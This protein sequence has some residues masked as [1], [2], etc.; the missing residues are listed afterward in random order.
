LPVAAEWSHLASARAVLDGGT[1]GGQTVLS[2]RWEPGPRLAEQVGVALGV[3]LLCVGIGLGVATGYWYVGLSIAAAL[4]ATALVLRYP[5][6]AVLLW[7]LVMPYF[8]GRASATNLAFV[9]SVHRLLIPMMLVLLFVYHRLG[10]RRSPF[11]LRAL[12]GALMLFIAIGV[13]NVLLT[14]GDTVRRLSFFHDQAIVPLCLFWLVRAIG[15]SER[16]LRRLVFV[17]FITVAVQSAV[18]LLSWFGPS[19]LPADWAIRAGER[20]VGTIGSPAP[21]TATIVL[22]GIFLLQ[23]TQSTPSRRVKTV[24]FVLL[25]LGL[26]AIFMSFSRGSWVGASLVFVGLLPLYPR[27]AVA[28]ATIVVVAGLALGAGPLATEVGFAQDRLSDSGTVAGRLVTDDAAVAMAASRPLTGWGFAQFEQFDEQFKR[29]VGGFAIQLGGSLHN[30][31]L[32]IATELGLPALLLYFAP[33][34]A[35]AI[36]TARRWR[37]MPRTGFVNHRLLA[38][39]WLAL[40]DQFVVS[41]FMDMF[42]SYPWGTGLWWTTLGFIAVILSSAPAEA[43][44]R[45]RTGDDTPAVLRRRIIEAGI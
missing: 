20:G 33:V 8:F 44:K 41:N 35:L 6:T 12:D 36:E 40:L 31:Y 43:R 27:V 25:L 23:F 9:W 26:G 28:L 19:V 16:D 3:L 42:H 11:R 13:A 38:L 15:P 4:P 18:G 29:E 21:F 34:T 37:R 24:A 32:G 45:S 10:L 2:R 22:F 39:L 7:A 30:S 1:L 17:A 5:W 14:H